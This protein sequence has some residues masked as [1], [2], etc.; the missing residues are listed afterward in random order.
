MQRHLDLIDRL[1]ADKDALAAQ[2][3]AVKKAAAEHE[4]KH[5][6]AIEA[7]KS[8]WA[9]ELRKQKEAWTAAEKVLFS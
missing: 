3:D 6:A 8:G 5:K 9:Q 1:L 4:V 7:L 2:V